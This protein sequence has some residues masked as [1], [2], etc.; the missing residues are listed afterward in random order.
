MVLT[1]SR[2]VVAALAAVLYA[3]AVA[4]QAPARSPAVAEKVTP[5]QLK[6]AIDLLGSVDFPIRMDA[7][8]TVRRADAA[9]AVPALIE[10]VTSHADAYVR[11]K[12]LVVLAGFN[13]PR[14]ADVML[15]S[16]DE[17]LFTLPADTI[18]L[19]GHG[20]DT[21]VGQERPHL[22]EWADRGF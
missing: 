19:P 4:A 15:K 21:T 16:L 3:P 6:S 9:L 2:F 13:D 12:A 14:I 10:A 1:R 22:Q 18:V 8:R 7:A 17:R 11:F 5:A 20:L